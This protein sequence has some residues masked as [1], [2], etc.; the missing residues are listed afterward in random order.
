[1][2]ACMVLY[3][4]YLD[5]LRRATTVPSDLGQGVSID[6]LRR[7]DASDR[8]A[9]SVDICKERNINLCCGN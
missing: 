5:P 4:G 7:F 9:D 6:F 2:L 3:R 8:V 1:V